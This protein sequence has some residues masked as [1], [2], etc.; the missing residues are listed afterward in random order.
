MKKTKK[1][2]I[3]TLLKAER[4]PTMN[5]W[6]GVTSLSRNVKLYNLNLTEE[7]LNI[8]YQL[9]FEDIQSDVV[10][11]II[12]DYSNQLIE[13]TNHQYTLGF[14]GRGGGYVVLY[15]VIDYKHSCDY[16]IAFGQGFLSGYDKDDLMELSWSELNEK[17]KIL[18]AFNSVVDSMINDFKYVL[19]HAQIEE[20]E[21]IN[22]VKV[23]YL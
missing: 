18:K 2:L 13:L 4:Y 3:D 15:S 9:L 22:K 6:N 5:S 19:S 17:Y 12:N 8:A 16:R 11:D 20:E 14:N 23:L 1:E 21:I 7:Q 10:D